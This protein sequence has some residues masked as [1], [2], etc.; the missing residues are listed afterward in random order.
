MSYTSHNE[1]SP[2]LEL[3]EPECA[4]MNSD[5]RTLVLLPGMDGTGTLFAPLIAAL[6]SD[7]KVIVLKYPTLIPLGYDELIDL[8]KVQ[9]PAEEDFLIL[10]SRF[11]VRSRSHWQRF[12]G[13]IYAV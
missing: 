11:Q 5:M 7:F 8:V 12:R 2:K 6:P 4:S 10:G 1:I 9:L 3:S 13:A